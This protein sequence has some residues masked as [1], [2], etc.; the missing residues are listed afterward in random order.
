[1]DPVKK[2]YRTGM[3]AAL[4]C[5]VLWGFLPIYWQ[6]L[7]PIESSV[8]IFYRIALVGVVCFIMAFALYGWQGILRHLAQKGAWRKFFLA[9]ILITFNWSLYIWAVNADLVIQTCIG[10]YIEPLVVSLLGVILF[11]ERLTFYKKAALILAGIGVLVIIVHFGEVPVVALTLAVTFAC[12]AALKKTFKVEAVLSLLY[13]TALLVPVSLAVVVWLE[14]RGEGALAQGTNWQFGLLLLAGVMTAV[15]L[16]LFAAAAK[17]IPLVT[18]GLTEY[19]A[20]SIT[21][22]I[23]IF[24]FR[25][26]FDLFQLIAFIVIWIGLGFFT[27]G[28]IKE[29]AQAKG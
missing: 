6:A 21:L 1:M 13:E 19:I 29:T 27:V 23:G 4:A 20:P 9:G 11:R 26:P 15:P 25:E 10:Y 28:E 24:M 17:R 3:A 7:R 18:L 5:A 22:V 2:E 14:V 8:I 12:Y 16:G